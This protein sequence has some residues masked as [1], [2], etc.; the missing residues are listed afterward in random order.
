MIKTIANNRKARHDYEIIN[1]IE[2]GIVLLGTE[3]KS[4]R[5]G[6]ANLAD[7]YARIRGNELWLVGLHISPYA[8]SII[9]NHDPMRDRK[10]LV[11]KLENAISARIFF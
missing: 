8:K 4:L 5:D 10:L 9:A 7:C 2:A 3:V 11:S 1:S 6:K